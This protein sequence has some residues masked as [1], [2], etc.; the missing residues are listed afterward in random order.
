M[1]TDEVKKTKR[2]RRKVNRSE[3]FHLWANTPTYHYYDG[4]NNLTSMHGFLFIGK[5]KSISKEDILSDWDWKWSH[6]CAGV[7]D[8]EKKLALIYSKYEYYYTS[9]AISDEYDYFITDEYI[10]SGELP[11][12][13]GLVK[14][15]AIYLV[16]QE[17]NYNYAQRYLY[18]AG[19]VRKVRVIS[20]RPTNLDY[21]HSLSEL[22]KFFKLKK[23][24][25]YT[26]P[27]KDTV[28][29]N[30]YGH[31]CITVPCPSVKRIIE[32][33]VFT[34]KEQRIL[35]IGDFYTKW[36]YGNGIS[37]AE[38]VKVWDKDFDEKLL[39]D[40]CKHY[41]VPVPSEMEMVDN[42]PQYR[43]RL[44]ECLDEHIISK[45]QDVY[46]Y[47]I[48]YKN[49]RI[50]K[51]RQRNLEIS[52]NNRRAAYDKLH[53]LSHDELL[54]IWR[55]ESNKT[56]EP[57]SYSSYSILNDSWKVID[58]T[59]EALS[60][61]D[62][63]LRLID[64]GATIETTRGARVPSLGAKRLFDMFNTLIRGVKATYT[65]DIEKIVL[66]NLNNLEFNINVR[67]NNL[68][69]YSSFHL[70]PAFTFRIGYYQLRELNYTYNTNIKRHDWLFVIGCHNIWLINFIE[71]VNHYKLNN[72]FNINNDYKITF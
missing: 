49:L 67:Y 58:I 34:K 4:G 2:I 63:Y 52:D 3:I 27:L 19:A 54:A 37:K 40:L 29:I 16:N 46:R 25:L 61:N 30:V 5:H 53:A 71:F 32:D 62:V 6:L 28:T 13:K 60:F 45:C 64:N 11:D 18:L 69:G 59:R 14:L 66:H 68:T 42:K 39:K 50:S 33:K 21:R 1:V 38:I 41:N 55:G 72:D 22:F 43:Y 36:C 10:K 15:N 35:A 65:Q 7:I 48:D 47:C 24:E 44:D 23:S 57:I 17:F 31:R 70:I 12:I 9:S 56:I 20:D 51:Y 26:K 8:Y